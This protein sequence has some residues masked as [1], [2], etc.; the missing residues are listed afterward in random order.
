MADLALMVSIILMYTIMFGVVGIFIMWKTPKNHLV[1]M[2]MIVLFLPAIYISAQLTFNIDRLTGRLLFGA[3]TAVI[4][5]A[6]I[7]LI[8]K[9]ITN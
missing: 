8:K 2:A 5:G 6:I 3:I 7:A 4:V 1:R 9:P